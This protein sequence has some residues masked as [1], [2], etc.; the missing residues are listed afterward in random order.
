VPAGEVP[1]GAIIGEKGA[2]KPGEVAE[3]HRAHAG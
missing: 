2:V 3:L 1:A